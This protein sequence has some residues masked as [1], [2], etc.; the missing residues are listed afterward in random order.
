MGIGQFL[1]DP[2]RLEAAIEYLE[3]ASVSAD[4]DIARRRLKQLFRPAG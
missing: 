2:V 4:P 1:D 3:R